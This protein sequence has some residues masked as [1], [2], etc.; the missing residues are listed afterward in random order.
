MPT[1]TR[2]TDPANPWAAH[3]TEFRGS[4]SRRDDGGSGDRKRAHRS[5]ADGRALRKASRRAPRSRALS[6]VG[7]GRTTQRRHRKPPSATLSPR[8]TE[9]LVERGSQKL[10]IIVRAF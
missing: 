3:R 8:M 6:R 2:Q 10:S 1:T 5:K 7:G 4:N 9:Y